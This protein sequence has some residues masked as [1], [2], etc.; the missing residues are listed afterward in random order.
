M[1]SLVA[2]VL[3]GDKDARER[4]IAHLRE[5]FVLLARRRTGSADAEDLAQEACMTV[6][7]KLNCGSKP[8]FFEAW[9]YQ[10][11]RNKIGNYLQSAQRRMVDD[12]AALESAGRPPIS[13]ESIQLRNDL[14]HCLAE[15]RRGRTIYLRTLN[16]AQLG[17][18][19]KEIC[20]KLNVTQNNMYVMLNRSRQMLRE[21]LKRTGRPK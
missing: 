6:V 19:S 3:E 16:L 21:C 12:P 20:K 7:E 9:A 14:R 1:N 4:L 10:I 5:R 8:E 17:F 18:S 13:V 11:L 2:Q 15:M